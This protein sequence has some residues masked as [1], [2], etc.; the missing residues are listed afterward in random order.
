MVSD[1]KSVCTRVIRINKGR[2][3]NVIRVMIH[4]RELCNIR[5]KLR[6]RP[7]SKQGTNV[8]VFHSQ[9]AAKQT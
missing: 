1:K 6:P 4:V 7:Q 9:A 8:P 2:K 5:F 3:K